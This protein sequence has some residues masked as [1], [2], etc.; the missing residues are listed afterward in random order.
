MMHRHSRRELALQEQ[1]STWCR[2]PNP[3]TEE[4]QDSALIERPQR[5]E[6]REILRQQRLHFLLLQRAM[7]SLS[8]E[9]CDGVA[10]GSAQLLPPADARTAL[11][12]NLEA[13]LL[14]ELCDESE[15]APSKD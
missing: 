14:A 4:R 2:A 10:P 15:W 5:E 11:Q 3:P 9:A 1:G 6:L 13:I 8:S 12:Q 7:D